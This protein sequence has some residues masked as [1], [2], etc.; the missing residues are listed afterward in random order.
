LPEK[1]FI[2]F[3]TFSLSLRHKD[4]MCFVMK[5]KAHI[6]YWKNSKV[7]FTEKFWKGRKLHIGFGWFFCFLQEKLKW[8]ITSLINTGNQVFNPTSK[9]FFSKKSRNQKEWAINIKFILFMR[10]ELFWVE[11]WK[12][13]AIFRLSST[14][15]KSQKIEI[16]ETS[17]HCN[18]KKRQVFVDKKNPPHI[19]PVLKIYFKQKLSKRIIPATIFNQFFF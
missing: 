15:F 18:K 16:I 3:Q 2:S 11:P 14:L 6:F 7:F 8:K 1:Y 4:E 19:F 13:F 9:G 12:S 5:K 17:V 10:P